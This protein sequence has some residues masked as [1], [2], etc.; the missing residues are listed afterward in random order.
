MGNMGG[1]GNNLKW[2]EVGY[3]GTA[4]EVRKRTIEEGTRG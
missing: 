3:H 4:K 2:Q 1:Q